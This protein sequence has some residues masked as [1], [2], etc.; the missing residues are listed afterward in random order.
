MENKEVIKIE[1]AKNAEAKDPTEKYTI[2]NYKLIKPVTFEGKEYKELT[3][4]FGSLT[5]NDS[6]VF[7]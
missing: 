5:G 4:D 1:D 6:I 3:L 7:L 2:L